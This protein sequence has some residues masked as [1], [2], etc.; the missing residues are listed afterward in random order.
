MY[1]CN[2]CKNKFRNKPFVGSNNKKYC[3]RKCTPN[4]VID[5]PYSFEYFNL[6]ESINDIESRVSDIK[7]IDDRFNLENEVNDLKTSYIIDMLGDDE[8]VFYKR[9]IYIELKT[10]NKLYDKIHNTFMNKKVRLRRAVIIYWDE[11]RSIVGNE[12]Y[13]MILKRFQE[14]MK[15]VTY[16]T[17]DFLFADPTYN[18]E[19]GHHTDKL[20]VKTLRQA[21]NIRKTYHENFNQYKSKL[22]NEQLNSLSCSNDC[23]AIENLA[24][25]VVCKEW[26]PWDNFFFDKKLNVY[27][28]G[29]WMDCSKYDDYYNDDN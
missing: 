18:N 3:S 8:G 11:L 29:I 24:Y 26:E 22:T 9:Q 1:T 20:H 21:Q 6:I 14:K 2:H 23:I 13:N 19:I 10:L 16:E 17:L 5:G 4:S 28:C 12:I 7:D 25:C 15:D 27:R